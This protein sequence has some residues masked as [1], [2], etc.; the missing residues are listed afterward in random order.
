MSRANH[1]FRR[2]NNVIKFGAAATLRNSVK[3]HT[4]ANERFREFRFFFSV[5]PYGFATAW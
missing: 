3:E 1:L 2:E 4:L 5:G